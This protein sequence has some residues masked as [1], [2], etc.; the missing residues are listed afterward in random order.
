MYL[1]VHRSRY[2]LFSKKITLVEK[3]KKNL[4]CIVIH[5]NRELIFCKLI[6][7]RAASVENLCKQLGP[8]SGPTKRRAWSGFKLFDTLMAFLQ[9]F[10]EKDDFDK[11]QQMT[12]K[13]Y[14]SM[15]QQT[16][17]QKKTNKKRRNELTL[18][19]IMSKKLVLIRDDVWWS[20]NDSFRELFSHCF[21]P[22]KL[23]MNSLKLSIHR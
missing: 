3:W 6:A 11:N 18:W 16:S 17:I 21:L 4:H 5:L 23:K 8:R 19:L 9:E 12:T 15:Q 22:F 10:W 1:L 7:C 20:D 2:V 13:A 14:K